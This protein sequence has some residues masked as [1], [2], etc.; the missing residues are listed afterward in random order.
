M[1]TNTTTTDAAQQPGAA[2]D[3]TTQQWVTGERARVL[4][5][6]QYTKILAI[7]RS[8][9]GREYLW[10]Q[11][12]RNP[13]AKDLAKAIS[14]TQHQIA[15]LEKLAPKMLTPLA[16][17][18]GLLALANDPAGSSFTL[19]QVFGTRGTALA[20]AQFEGAAARAAI[21]AAKG[22]QS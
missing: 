3:Y 10:M 8:D 13:S 17:L 14:I 6:E 7:L 11:G 18:E 20:D 1:K 9:K 16:A 21:Y 4:N 2:Y 22:G 5:L 15:H 12:N 19:A